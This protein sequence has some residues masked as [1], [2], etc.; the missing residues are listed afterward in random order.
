M[1]LWTIDSLLNETHNSTQLTD[2]QKIQFL[3]YMNDH[4]S[5]STFY[6]NRELRHSALQNMNSTR[7]ALAESE[8]QFPSFVNYESISSSPQSLKD[9]ALIFTAGGEGERL[10]LSL[11][12]QGI[13]ASDLEDFTKA[14][15]YLPEFYKKYGTLHVNLAMVS[16]FCNKYNIN[17]PVI[18]TTGPAD[19][20]T[21]RVIPEI[22]EKYSNFG[23]KNIRVI[24]Q[25][26]RLHLTNE[27]KIVWQI[28]DNMVVPATNP[29]ETG[30]PLMKLKDR[31]D[32]DG[33]VLD[34]LKKIGCS[35]SVVVQAT[36]LYDKRLLPMMGAA[37]AGHDC[38][39]VGILRNSFPQKDPFGTFVTLK[40]ESIEKTMILEQDVRNDKTREIVDKSGKYFL[41]C[42]TG[43]Y[44][45]EN[46]LLNNND[47]PDF[48]TPPKEILPDI[49]RASKIGYA[50]TDIVP[51]AKNPVILTIDNEMFGV[52]KTSDDLKILSELGRK[53]GLD[54]LCDEQERIYNN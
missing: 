28:I 44:A 50:A 43:F 20:I 32:K 31:S 9:H 26:V 5:P 53:Y 6:R 40:K 14:T 45:F 34:W 39:A 16:S 48:A 52:L 11:L 37:L 13:P 19:S 25:D 51:C 10:R 38:L 29:D 33:S 49:P 22:L 2:I 1:E 30:G 12:K 36:A 21:A 23:L 54:K 15:F 42:N 35:R 4:F 41:P 8:Q 3:N 27:D 24:E 17:I 47:L 18:V 46:D 7:N